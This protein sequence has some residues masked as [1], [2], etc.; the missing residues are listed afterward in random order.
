MPDVVFTSAFLQVDLGYLVVAGVRVRYVND[1]DRP[2][3]RIGVTAGGVEQQLLAAAVREAQIV[4]VPSAAAAVPMLA[5]G[6]IDAFAADKPALARVAAPL[7]GTRMIEGR[8]GVLRIAAALHAS[9]Q[10][11]LPFVQQFVSAA[12]SEGLVDRAAQEAGIVGPV[13]PGVR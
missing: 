12:M 5:S 6:R 11:G 4:P 8:W 13:T 9:R 10:A 1:M 3:L 7:S 2:D